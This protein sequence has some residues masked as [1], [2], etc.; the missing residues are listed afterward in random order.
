MQNLIVMFTFSFFDWK[1]PFW[2]NFFPKNGSCNF[3]LNVRTESDRNMQIVIGM[4]TFSALD[5]KDPF[6]ANL[7]QQ[8]KIAILS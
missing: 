6:L 7:V 5:Q 3:K 1:F 8:R 2:V 4:R